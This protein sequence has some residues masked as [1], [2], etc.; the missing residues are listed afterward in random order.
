VSSKLVIIN[1]RAVTPDGVVENA[2]LV[3]SRGIIVEIGPAGQ[4]RCAPGGRKGEPV[5][6]AGGAWMLPGCIDLHSDAVEREIEPRPRA[7]FPVELAFRELEKRLAGCGITTIFHSLS[8]AK[9]QLGL[10]S[11]K[12]AA[13]VIR[14]ICELA[15]G[16]ALIRHRIHLRYEITDLSAVPL[17]MELLN[18]GKVDLLSF[19][20]HTPGQ[21]QFR[22]LEK[23]KEWVRWSYGVREEEMEELLAKKDVDREQ[24][25]AAMRR[26]ASKARELGIPVAS[27]DDDCPARVAM[28]HELGSSISEFPVNL[29]TASYAR[30]RGL[31][32]C[33]GAPNVVRGGSQAHNLSAR[34]A[35]AAGAAD[36]LCSDYYPPAMLCAVFRLAKTPDSLPRSMSLVS[37]NPARAV[38]L[39]GEVGALEVG[40]R[41]DLV[42]VNLEEGIPRVLITMVDGRVVY[43]LNYRYAGEQ[44]TACDNQSL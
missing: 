18:E 26:L 35:V 9:E 24:V 38:G 11:N 3:V 32:V 29:E 34:D 23:Y 42:L 8:F 1:G 16:P 36:I 20:D 43:S 4:V 31:H 27:H 44:V 17:I 5:L 25:Q 41:A 40:R 7:V 10:R 19:M 15:A 39:A 30:E 12:M 22:E 14:R 28:A 2:C 21:G 37:A 6:D 13:R 33:V